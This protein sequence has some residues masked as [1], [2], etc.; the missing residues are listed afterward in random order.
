MAWNRH[1]C[2][3]S[4]MVNFVCPQVWAYYIY[5]QDKTMKL[6]SL[7]QKYSSTKFQENSRIYTYNSFWAYTLAEHQKDFTFISGKF[8]NICT[9]CLVSS[10]WLAETLKIKTLFHYIS[11]FNYLFIIQSNMIKRS[12]DQPIIHWKNILINLRVI[13][14]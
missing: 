6:T 7:E 4:C 9:L 10:K 2:A 11:E 5:V 13:N 8:K 12:Y 3:S 1:L 14:K